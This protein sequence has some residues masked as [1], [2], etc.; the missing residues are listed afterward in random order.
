MRSASTL[1]FASF[2]VCSWAGP[3]VNSFRAGTDWAQRTTS[4][5]IEVTG[6]IT[7]TITG[8]PTAYGTLTKA[9]G[10]LNGSAN[11]QDLNPDFPIAATAY[12]TGTELSNERVQWAVTAPAAIGQNVVVNGVTIKITQVS[13]TLTSVMSVLASPLLDPVSYRP[14]TVQIAKSS[15]DTNT[16]VIRGLVNGFPFLPVVA[17]VTAMEYDGFGGGAGLGVVR[18][19]ATLQGAA[20][21]AGLSMSVDV[22]GT[23]YSAPVSA[24]NEWFVITPAAGLATVVTKLPTSLT[25]RTTNFDLGTGT[26]LSATYLNGDC[27]N[28][29]LVDIADYTLLATAFD[30][31]PTSGNWNVAADLNRDG[32]VDIADYTLLALNFDGVGE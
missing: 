5:T 13:G 8:T 7:Q 19:T 25:R 26:A 3:A 23:P 17:T 2:V 24:T 31:T 1:L 22:N 32:V 20:S 16:L 14:R 10:S 21:A 9:A 4:S 6:T 30:A 12:F 29:N 18:G 28:N 11:L 15:A 27:T